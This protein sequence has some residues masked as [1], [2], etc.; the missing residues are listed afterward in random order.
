MTEELSA[1]KK[2]AYKVN[3]VGILRVD[4]E[5]FISLIECSLHGL[6]RRYCSSTFEDGDRLKVGRDASSDL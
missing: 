2:N 5:Y 3:I 6:T 4:E 1:R